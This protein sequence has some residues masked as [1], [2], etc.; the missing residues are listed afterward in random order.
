M[1]FPSDKKNIQVTNKFP[2][3]KR[4]GDFILKMETILKIIYVIYLDTI[5]LWINSVTR[6]YTDQFL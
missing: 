5:L 6:S 2:Y 1:F 4:P 3:G